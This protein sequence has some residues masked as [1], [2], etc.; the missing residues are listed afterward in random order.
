MFR[1]SARAEKQK[2]MKQDFGFNPSVTKHTE[3]AQN[4]EGLGDGGW[5]GGDVRGSQSRKMIHCLWRGDRCR[6]A[7]CSN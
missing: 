6:Q 5:G 2:Y 4:E 3:L 1:P 7:P